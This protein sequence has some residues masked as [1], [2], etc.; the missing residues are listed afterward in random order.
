MEEEFWDYLFSSSK[1]TWG[2]LV[3]EQDWLDVTIIKL[4]ALRV[5]LSDCVI[6]LL[7]SLRVSRA[8]YYIVSDV[9]Y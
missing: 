3:Y 9:R 1:N 8:A 2:L 4:Q 7:I 5:S 6:T